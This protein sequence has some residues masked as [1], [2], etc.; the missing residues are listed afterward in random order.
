M[1]G[2]LLKQGVI[3]HFNR[4][5]CVKF[6]PD[7]HIIYSGG[8]DRIV[9]IHDVRIKDPVKTILGPYVIGDAIDVRDNELLTGS[10]RSKD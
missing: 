1:S 3:N 5:H 6:D 8:A 4:I 9:T 2:D 7:E 10:Y